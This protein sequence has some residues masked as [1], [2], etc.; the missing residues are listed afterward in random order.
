MSERR[1][2]EIVLIIHPNHSEEAPKML[3]RFQ[4]FFV[5]KKG[6]IHRQEDWG[7]RPLSYSIK[8]AHKAH[9]I[10][11]NVECAANV[12][13]AFMDSI[14]Y[15]DTIIRK[16]TIKRK[17]AIKDR[18]IM[19]DLK[20]DKKFKRTKL[21]FENIDYKAIDLLRKHLME[22]YRIIPSRTSGATAKEQRALSNAIK[23]ARTLA[24]IPYCDRHR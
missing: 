3:E 18:S 2:Y 23:I 8:R 5:E 9:Y 7:R 16:L 17:Q 15:N 24:L 19:M 21:S 12:Y 22:T 13:R 1:H 14:R 20:D 6:S 4:M 11:F 10:M